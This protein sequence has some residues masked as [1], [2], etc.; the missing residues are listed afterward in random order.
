MRNIVADVLCLLDPLKSLLCSRT[1]C[2]KGARSISNFTVIEELVEDFFQTCA[3]TMLLCQHMWGEA[4]P[5]KPLLERNQTLISERIVQ[6]SSG[7]IESLDDWRKLQRIANENE[8]RQRSGVPG[9]CQQS[10]D[11]TCLACFVDK[12]KHEIFNVI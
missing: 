7:K 11:F 6:R 1:L 12:D 4:S 3:K 5:P 2:E 8:T 9:S 10:F